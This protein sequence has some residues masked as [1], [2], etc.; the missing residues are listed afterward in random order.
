MKS[1]VQW[2]RGCATPVPHP[3]AWHWAARAG[4]PGH[5]RRGAR[6]RS[7]IGTNQSQVRNL[8]G[9]TTQDGGPGELVSPGSLPRENVFPHVLSASREM[10]SALLEA[11]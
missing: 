9:G 7:E 1:R 10:R 2:I 5:W 11:T 6:G 4:G 3:G 8:A